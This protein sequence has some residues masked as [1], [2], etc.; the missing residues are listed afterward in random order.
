MN[1]RVENLVRIGA[2]A[3]TAFALLLP[4]NPGF[5]TAGNG[6]CTQ[7]LVAG[8][9]CDGTGSSVCTTGAMKCGTGTS[10]SS[11]SDG[12]GDEVKCQKVGGCAS[13]AGG[14]PKEPRSNA[15]GC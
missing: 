9:K 3:A 13:P 15:T 6:N 7:A 14:N 1:V 2:I 10:L 12:A 5:F 8:D 11:C 4:A